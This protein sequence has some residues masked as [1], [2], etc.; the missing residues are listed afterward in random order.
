M[1]WL[2]IGLRAS[3]LTCAVLGVACG[4]DEVTSPVS[5]QYRRSPSLT[6]VP[7]TSVVI[8]SGDTYLKG[9]TP[10]KNQGTELILRVQ[11]SGN[12]RVLVA[13]STS[14]ISAA[15]GA[16]SIVSARIQLTIS[17]NGNN[18]GTSGRAIS[19]H[20]LTTQWSELGATWNCAADANPS[21]SVPDCSGAAAWAMSGSQARP[22]D[23][24]A[25]DTAIIQS[26]QSGTVSFDVTSDI[27]SI[28]NGSRA[29]F[30]WIVKK[31][32]EGAAGRVDFASRETGSDGPQLILVVSPPPPPI[33]TGEWGGIQSEND[34]AL[35]HAANYPLHV[36]FGTGKVIDGACVNY[37][38]IASISAPNIIINY[39]GCGIDT[40]EFSYDGGTLLAVGTRTAFS[41][42]RSV[43]L[44]WTLQEDPSVWTP[45]TGEWSGIVTITDPENGNVPHQY[46]LLID[47]SSGQAIS[48]ACASQGQLVDVTASVLRLAYAPGCQVE[49]VNYSVTGNELD[50]A[51]NGI[52]YSDGRPLPSAWQLQ[53]VSSTA[54][55]IVFSSDRESPGRH[56]IFAMSDDGSN[57]ARL[58]TSGSLDFMPRWSP[59][60]SKI[61]FASE[62]SG[63]RQIWVMNADGS[64]PVQLT[65]LGGL[66]HEPDWSPDGLQIAF[67]SSSV[68]YNQIFVMNADG[69]NAHRLTSNSGDY[70]PSWSPFG[71][72]I[73]FTRISSNSVQDIF[74]MNVDGSNAVA[75]TSNTGVNYTPAWSPDG[76]K[77]AFTSD[78]NGGQNVWRMNADGSG[79]VQ[80]TF[81]ATSYSP[82]WTPG[83]DSILFAS[84]RS[85]VYQVYRMA[86]DGSGLVQL[87]APPSGESYGPSR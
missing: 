31:T 48:A 64:N 37:G 11:D 22:W 1:S 46:S 75:L 25:S 60:R 67:T 43:P 35:G 33:P 78:R 54:L 15:V 40:V 24:T 44:S 68:G 76:S 72:K 52:A 85:G 27:A 21:N 2:R 65:S 45:P 83:S 36:D 71:D 38:Q 41:D 26:H 66:N 42:G 39:P 20:R 59:D 12:N 82:A 84:N 86:L 9:G 34:P 14:D 61:A 13:F 55:S 32:E 74:V 63:S 5:T 17:D 62:R 56:Q 69:S 6:V 87:S 77:L 8:A 53:P 3:L 29:N 49:T 23:S 50:A 57:V 81:A 79:Q 19:L 7:S 70:H 18:W 47:F 51:G 16:G 10:N 80:L 73:A 4:R 30:G 28:A 58:T